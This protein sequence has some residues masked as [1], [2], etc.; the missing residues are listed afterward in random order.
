MLFGSRAERDEARR[1]LI[2]VDRKD[3]KALRRAVTAVRDGD[4]AWVE[5]TA[6][7]AS[8]AAVRTW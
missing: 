3:M 8:Q 4:P 7:P 2:A 5:G 1:I 6:P